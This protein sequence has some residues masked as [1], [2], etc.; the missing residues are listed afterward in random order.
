MNQVEIM[1]FVNK[2]P[3]FTLATCVDGVPYVRT[4]MLA[5]ADSR[6]IIFSTGKEKDVCKQM[7]ANPKVELCFYSAADEKQL[8]IAARA[9][10]IVRVAQS[11]KRWP[12][13]LGFAT[14]RLGVGSGLRPSQILRLELT[15]DG[16][17]VDS[18][19]VG[20]RRLM[21]GR[22]YESNYFH[23]YFDYLPDPSPGS[24]ER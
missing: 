22:V 5:F 13:C 23:Y 15:V 14:K 21:R 8:R 18:E 9:E 7:Q 12:V 1:E 10:E 3:I 4:M 20:N 6:G 2:N 24:G 19:A 16:E 17:V 11:T